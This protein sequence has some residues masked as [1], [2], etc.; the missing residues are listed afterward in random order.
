MTSA[1][2]KIVTLQEDKA[3]EEESSAIEENCEMELGYVESL[4]P[5]I[6]KSL[7]LNQ[8]ISKNTFDQAYT[9]QEKVTFSCK[10]GIS[11]SLSVLINKKVS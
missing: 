1:K 8:K 4:H 6:L 3:L 9:I 5:Q 7:M 10:S 2:F 11:N